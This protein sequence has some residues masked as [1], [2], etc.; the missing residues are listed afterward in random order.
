MLEYAKKYE[1]YLVIQDQSKV[2]AIL[3]EINE[4]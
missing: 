1:E 2:V 4:H 3:G